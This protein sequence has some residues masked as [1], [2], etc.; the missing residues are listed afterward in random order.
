MVTEPVGASLLCT[1]NALE[2][3]TS[4]ATSVPPV[5]STASVS[6]KFTVLV[7]VITAGTLITLMAIDAVELKPATSVTCTVT[8]CAILLS[9]LL[10]TLQM[11]AP[12]AVVVPN[13]VMAPMS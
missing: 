3:S 5:V 7:P 2:L 4:V 1:T 11:P 13:T 6:T 8:V 12:P 10:V 9:V